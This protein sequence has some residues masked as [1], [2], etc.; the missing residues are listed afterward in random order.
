MYRPAE[1]VVYEAGRVQG[2]GPVGD[3]LHM[4]WAV[5]TFDVAA[6]QRGQCLGMDLVVVV[7][8]GGGGRGGAPC[9]PDSLEV[10][11]T[12]DVPVGAV[13]MWLGEGGAQ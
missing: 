9:V 2:V 11:V 5:G 1:V 6:K 10:G 8:G 7:V 4:L 3:G 13:F 12:K